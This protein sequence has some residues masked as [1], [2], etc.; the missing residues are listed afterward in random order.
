MSGSSLRKN[1]SRRDFLM[2]GA[3]SAAVVLSQ[4]CAQQAPAAKPTSAPAAAPPTQAAPAVPTPTSAAQVPAVNVGLA[5]PTAAPTQAA[6]QAAKPAGAKKGGT[7][8]VAK[9]T[10]MRE[11]DPFQVG[12]GHYTWI[13]AFWN[14]P[15]RY[16]AQLNP[17]PELAE[18]WAFSPDNL[19]MTLHLRHGV[20]FHSGREFNSSDVKATVEFASGDALASLQGMYQTIKEVATPDP[21]T[22]VLKFDKVQP[23]IFD[24]LDGLYIID[25]E[26]I[27]QRTKTAVGTG[28]YKMAKYTPNDSVE[29]VAFSDYWEAGKP[30]IEKFIVRQIPDLSAMA[31]NL[32]SGVVDAAW[33]VNYPDLTRL[34]DTGKFTMDLGAPGAFKFSLELNCKRAPL[35]NKKVRQALAWATD[36]KR[37]CETG[38]YSLVPPTPLLWPEHSWAYFKDL[39]SSMGFD[40]EKAKQLL[41][42]SGVPNG[43]DLEILGASGTG[44]GHGPLMQI[45]QSDLKK[46]GINATI[47]DLDV[48]QTDDRRNKADYQATIH[49]FGRGNRDP[50]SVFVGTKSLYSAKEGGWTNIDSA[51]YDRLRAELQ[52]T[53]DREPRK[54][55]ARKL[56]ELLFD[57]CFNNPVAYQPR[58]WL[59]AP[60]VKGLAYNMDN[61]PFVAD[62]WLDK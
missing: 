33:N 38:L 25:K 16:D 17:Q 62:M 5:A 37:F 20:K 3:A 10:P 12:P 50:G 44:P 21:Y 52:S 51:E 4:A 59:L 41:A 13:R 48:S 19:E 34:R 30:Y 23:G 22:A 18:S 15:V 45:I 39:E 61:T 14:T 28:P 56:Q 11:F 2:L 31:I 24:M 6:A 8:T 40:L 26:T 46:L 36:R 29:T 60:Y 53:L 27:D 7:F 55:T 35:D 57:E 54:A 1:L 42:E 9:P 47:A 43:F 58:A 49:T 32:E